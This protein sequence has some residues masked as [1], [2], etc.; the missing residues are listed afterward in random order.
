[1]T[2]VVA[3]DPPLEELDELGPLGPRADDR[4]LAEQHVEQLGQL[5]DRG[6]PD[7]AADGRAAVGALDAARRRVLGQQHRDV[8]LRP[9]IVGDPHRAELEQVERAAVAADPALAE[10]DRAGGGGLDRD[11]HRDQERRQQQDQEGR[12]DAVTRVLEREL[13][14]LGL[15]G[16]QAE[17]RHPADVL[18][19]RADVHALPQARDQRDLQAEL[20]ALA[21]ERHELGVRPARGQEREHDVL[22]ARLG[23]DRRQVGG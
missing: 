23:D 7:H 8:V 12:G 4:H 20:V 5:V 14:A 16:V 11:R 13:P 10:E 21:D 18:E 3:V 1:V 6:P 19:R 22:G 17:E 9:R 15:D 2:V